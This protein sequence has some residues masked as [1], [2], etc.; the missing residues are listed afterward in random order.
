MMIEW[1]I[2]LIKIGIECTFEKLRCELLE[3]PEWYFFVLLMDEQAA[4]SI[5]TCNAQGDDIRAH[6]IDGLVPDSMGNMSSI[7][8]DG[9]KE[10][11]I[12][13]KDAE[14]FSLKGREYPIASMLKEEIS[15]MP[16]LINWIMTTI[17]KDGRHIL[18]Y[19]SWS[20]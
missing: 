13:R 7:F 9:I 12:E 19:P 8:E 17:L 2:N 5:R 18:I 4:L 16:G 1:G 20:I 3:H 6:I 14:T 11:L 10:T 15:S